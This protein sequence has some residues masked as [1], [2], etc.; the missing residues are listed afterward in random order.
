M[1][2]AIAVGH[3][4]ESYQV[5][6]LL[7]KFGHTVSY[8]TALQLES[9]LAQLRLLPQQM[10]TAGIQAGQHTTLVWDNCQEVT[11]HTIHTNGILIKI[12]LILFIRSCCKIKLE[13]ESLVEKIVLP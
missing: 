12:L 8:N 4:T 1:S 11:L 2:L 7:N 13:E 9:G 10:L 3:L 5:V 6:D